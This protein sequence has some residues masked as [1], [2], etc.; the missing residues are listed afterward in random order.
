MPINLLVLELLQE[1]SDSGRTAEDVCKDRPDLA[2]EIR[3]YLRQSQAQAMRVAHRANRAVFFK[4]SL[5]H[6]TDTCRFKEGYLN[7]R[8]NV[9]FLFGQFGSAP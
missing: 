9:S 7:K 4:S 8:I 5:F 6:K 1:A 3:E 2:G